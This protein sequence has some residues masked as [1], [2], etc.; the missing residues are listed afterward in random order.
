MV[1]TEIESRLGAS[2]IRPFL[3]FEQAGKI[4]GEIGESRAMAT[5]PAAASSRASSLR[6]CVLIV[7]WYVANGV[8]NDQNKNVLRVLRLPFLIAAMQARRARLPRR[9]RAA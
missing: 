9:L 4:G 8:Y 7:L 5:N 3:R 6:K 1:E 2:I